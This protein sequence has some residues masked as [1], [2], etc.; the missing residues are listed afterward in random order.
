[1]S[2]RIEQCLLSHAIEHKLFQALEKNKITE[3]Y[4]FD[5]QYRDL[6]LLI[7]D[8]F[9]RN[10]DTPDPATLHG[11][12][13]NL[14]LQWGIQDNIDGMCEELRR[15]K[16]RADAI[17]LSEHIRAAADSTNPREALEILRNAS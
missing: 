1:M 15:V 9:R 8:Y 11:M 14:N 17:R 7:R 12:R 6:Y 4:F 2:A 16:I 13:P 3:E 5:T 10:G